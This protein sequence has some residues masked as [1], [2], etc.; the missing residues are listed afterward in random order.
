MMMGL[1][2]DVDGLEL[3]EAFSAEEYVKN[4]SREQ[5]RE[6]LRVVA[7]NLSYDADYHIYGQ[8]GHQVC[9]G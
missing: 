6:L 5:Q 8:V 3:D 1:Q 4:L 2:K 9:T 7:A